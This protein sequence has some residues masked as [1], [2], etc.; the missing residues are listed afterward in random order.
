LVD[1]IE[2]LG[3]AKLQD[4]AVAEPQGLIGLSL[5]VVSADRIAVRRRSRRGQMDL[6]WIFLE[7][8]DLASAKKSWARTASSL[9]TAL[10]FVIHFLIRRA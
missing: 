8:I 3:V 10:A 1:A 5:P 2:I 7:V 9:P 4:L 6:R